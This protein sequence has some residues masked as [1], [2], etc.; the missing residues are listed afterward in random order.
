CQAAIF[1]REGTHENQAFRSHNL[2]VDESS[3]QHRSAWHLEAVVKYSTRPQIHFAVSHSATCG[4]PPALEVLRI[5][6]R[7]ED[8]ISR[9]I[10]DPRKDER[11]F[12]WLNDCQLDLCQ[13][14]SEA[15]HGL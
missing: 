14:M 8:D 12:R 6:P 9:S 1:I 11:F 5:G 3:P 2:A 15:L 10:Q 4:P 13:M 7:M